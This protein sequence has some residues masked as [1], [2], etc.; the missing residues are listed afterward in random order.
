MHLL[1]VGNGLALLGITT[2][3]CEV[4][5]MNFIKVSNIRKLCSIPSDILYENL[6]SHKIIM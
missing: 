4:V 5:L 6:A 1:K 3:V 2:V